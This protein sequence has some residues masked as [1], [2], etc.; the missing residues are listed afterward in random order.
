MLVFEIYVRTGLCRF[1]VGFEVG[2]GLEEEG[3]LVADGNGMLNKGESFTFI[4][5]YDTGHAMFTF[6]KN[7]PPR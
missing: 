2:N 5:Y 1:G 3:G 6:Q 4:Y 7:R